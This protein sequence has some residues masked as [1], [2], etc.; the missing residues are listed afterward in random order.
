MTLLNSLTA[1]GQGKIVD[2]LKTGFWTETF[3]DANRKYVLKGN[4]KVIPLKQYQIIRE[5]G[6]TCYEVKFKGSTPLMFYDGKSK[7]NISVKDSIWNSYDQAGNLREIDYWIAG[8]NQWTKYYDEKGNLIRYDYDDYESDTS[9]QLTY[10]NGRLFKK[11]FYPPENKNRQAEIYYPTDALIISN[12]ELSFTINFLDKPTASEEISISSKNDLTINSISS[13]R[14]FVTLVTSNNQP[15]TFPLQIKANTIF[16]L[17]VIASPTSANYQMTDT[18][19][20]VTSE[21]KTSYEIYTSIYAHHING[22]T[23]ENLT[24]LQ[25]SK[26]KDKYLILPSMGTV[27]DA[28]IISKSGDKSFYE[29]NGTTKIDLSKFSA[30]TYQLLVSSCHTGGQLKFVITE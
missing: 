14:S 21:N 23:V 11:A 28:T 27:T 10:I 8:L 18:L 9:F 13:K 17:K 26:T 24:S 6:N 15:I 12:A 1:L 22:R 4:Y 7:S 16:P 30:G 2:G 25:L 20:V 5:L 3:E 29:I 19:T